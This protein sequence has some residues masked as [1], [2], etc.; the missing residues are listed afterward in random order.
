[1]LKMAV[2]I[3]MLFGKVGVTSPCKDE[4]L[5]KNGW[6]VSCVRGVRVALLQAQTCC[7]WAYK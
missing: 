6:E 2:A 4:N 3:V 7:T 1:M 5:K